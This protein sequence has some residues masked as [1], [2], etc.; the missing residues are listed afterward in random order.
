MPDYAGPSHHLLQAAFP[1]T[2]QE[3]GLTY[4]SGCLQ[5][6]TYLFL[7]EKLNLNMQPGYSF[8]NQSPRFLHL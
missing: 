2:L 6:L 1:G 7:S 4:S 8:L 3:Q 5:V